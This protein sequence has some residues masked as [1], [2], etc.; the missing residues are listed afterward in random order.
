M[1]G[2]WITATTLGLLFALSASTARASGFGLNEHSARPMGMAG[3]FT[4]IADS[5]AAMFHN[6]A[7]LA[8][9][10]GL[11]LEVG[12][13]VIAPTSTYRGMVPELHIEAKIGATENIFFVP[14]FYA[15]YRIHDRVAAGFG[16][17]MPYGLTQEWPR[18]V[19]VNGQQVPWWGRGMVE[20]IALQPFY[21]TPQVA[22]NV[23]P[24]VQLGAGLYVVKAA[25]EMTRS[26]TFSNNL[27]DDISVDLAAGGVGVSAT[28]GL[29]VTVIPDLL[30]AGFTYRGGLA[31]DLEG[32]AA[33]TKNGSPDNI[34]PGL[35]A[36]LTDGPGAT[37]I[38]IPH[39]L[40]FGLAAF[41][42][43]PLAVSFNFEV[44]T[45]SDYKN[46]AISFGPTAEVPDRSELDSV[47]PKDW[48][49]TIVV[50]LG[51][52]YRV[53]PSLAVRAGFVYDQ[54]PAPLHTVG[55]ELPDAD[56]Y[57]LSL[58]GGYEWRGLRADLAYQF[59]TTQ[60]IRGADVARLPGFWQAKAHLVGISLGYALSL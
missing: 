35:R 41:P 54:S 22:V 36:R 51:A 46:L 4:A 58:G 47:V 14:N 43:K 3:A 31:L 21:F 7:G 25:V 2:N 12:G 38:N 24:R 50:R 29:L 1:R 5:P 55:P 42:I 23:H 16:V 10:P 13:T 60:E 18:T 6:P 27:E 59:L 37:T 32:N 52:E 11:Q 34:P 49:N 40:S 17:F 30:K 8:L 26:V 45:W 33:F 56:R 57:E 53:L 44:I 20:R 9:L 19:T 28:A 15:S 48:S 39:V